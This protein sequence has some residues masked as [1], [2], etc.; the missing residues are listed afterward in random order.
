M[1]DVK[2][3]ET[4]MM[5]TIRK[6]N[7]FFIDFASADMRPRTAEITAILGER[8]LKNAKFRG[9]FKEIDKLSGF[10][11]KKRDSPIFTDAQTVFYG[12]RGSDF[13]GDCEKS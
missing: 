13:R 7:I 4:A 9:C 10:S 12:K 1:H 2:L 5:A 11:N 6:T 3:A 8:I